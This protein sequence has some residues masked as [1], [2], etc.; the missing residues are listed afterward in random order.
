MKSILCLDDLNN[1]LLPWARQHAENFDFS[2]EAKV[3]SLETY[4]TRI[5]EEI[6][7]RLSNFTPLTNFAGREMPGAPKAHMRILVTGLED[8][9]A[10]FWLQLYKKTLQ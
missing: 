1:H 2:L 4:Q 6:E 5:R 10:K 3:C 7:Q 8:F 9:S